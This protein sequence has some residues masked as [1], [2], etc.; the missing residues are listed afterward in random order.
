M[1]ASLLVTLAVIGLSAGSALAVSPPEPE[2][3][4]LGTT[5]TTAKPGSK[6]CSVIDPGN[7][8]DTFNVVDS[9][10]RE[11][12]EAFA[13]KMAAKTFQLGCLYDG[14]IDFGAAGGENPLPN[15]GW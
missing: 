6:V 9:W 8:R 11:T 7:W 13:K 4:K 12:C 15:C 1:R 3:F 10:K 5:A 2:A 14:G